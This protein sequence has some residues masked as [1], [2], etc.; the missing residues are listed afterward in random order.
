[1]KNHRHIGA[2]LLCMWSSEHEAVMSASST[3]HKRS[4]LLNTH[5]FVKLTF[6]TLEARI[7]WTLTDVSPPLTG[8]FETTA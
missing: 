7:E 1:M 8:Y 3:L 5:S 6:K 2:F 4:Q